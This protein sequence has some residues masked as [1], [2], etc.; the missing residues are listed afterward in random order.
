MSRSAIL[1]PCLMMADAVSNDIIGRYIDRA[2]TEQEGE[3][4]YSRWLRSVSM[5]ICCAAW[6][7]VRRG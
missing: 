5:A 6:Q 4:I 3:Q 2:L 1:N 7:S